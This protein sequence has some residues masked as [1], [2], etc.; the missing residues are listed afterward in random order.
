M[1]P[2][3]KIPVSNPHQKP[4][5]PELK[6]VSHEYRL[7]DTGQVYSI[8]LPS[9][10]VTFWSCFNKVLDDYGVLSEMVMKS[11]W[12]MHMSLKTLSF[13]IELTQV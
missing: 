5:D 10:V 6:A 7:G 12:E 13:K 1:V 3:S 9:T 2:A 4:R 11:T 8:I